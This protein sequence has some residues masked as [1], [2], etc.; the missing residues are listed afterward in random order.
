MPVCVYICLSGDTIYERKH[1]LRLELDSFVLLS[2]KDSNNTEIF[3]VKM[4]PFYLL[5]AEPTVLIV[6][7]KQQQLR[8]KSTP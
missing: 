2:G 3:G 8:Q 6:P 1:D 7:H 4:F 5:Q